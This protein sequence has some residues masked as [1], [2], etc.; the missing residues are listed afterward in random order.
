MK[1]VAAKVYKTRISSGE[2]AGEIAACG[3]GKIIPH[4]CGA[5]AAQGNVRAPHGLEDIVFNHCIGNRRISEIDSRIG[6]PDKRIV[7]NIEP[8][9]WTGAAVKIETPGDITNE[10]IANGYV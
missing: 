2:V 4:A 7:H 10:I 1:I 5:V 3:I 9:D 6:Q 8:S